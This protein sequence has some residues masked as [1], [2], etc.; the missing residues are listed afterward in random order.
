M[1]ENERL[2]SEEKGGTDG[3]L[4]ERGSTTGGPYATPLP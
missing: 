2:G 4:E 3:L 1:E